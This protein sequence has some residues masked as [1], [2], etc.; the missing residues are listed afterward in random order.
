[1]DDP[2]GTIDQEIAAF[3]RAE[4]EYLGEPTIREL[5]STYPNNLKVE[6]IL[7][8]VI[9]IS[10][11]YH[12]RVLDND[13]QPLARH[14]HTIDDL[15]GRLRRGDPS[16]VDAIIKS[17]GTTKQYFSFATKFCSWHNQEAYAIYDT[18]MWKALSAYR[19]AGRFTFRASESDD[20]VG[21]HEVVRRFQKAYGLEA[22]SLRDIDKFLWRVGDRLLGA[23]S[24]G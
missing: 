8:K 16:V 21:F 7:V 23:P 18:Y 9:T 11:L 10:S 22:Y 3:D 4:K 12:A 15:D 24:E 6:H 13:F 2:K 5:I 20:Y 19:A 1:M 14:I 17:Q